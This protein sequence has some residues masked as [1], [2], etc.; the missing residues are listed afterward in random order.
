MNRYIE[1]GKK[2]F[3]EN[4]GQLINPYKIGSQEYNDFERGWTQAL[5]QSSDSLIRE[6]ER[7]GSY[8]KLKE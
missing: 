7:K 4:R 5:K 6:Y 8:N 2:S 1:E 3:H